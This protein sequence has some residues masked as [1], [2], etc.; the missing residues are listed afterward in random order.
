MSE[1][2]SRAVYLVGSIPLADAEEVFD[3][4]AGAVGELVPAIPDGETGPARSLWVQCQIPFLLMHP[5]LRMMQRDP[6]RPDEWR[7]VRIKS[8]GIYSPKPEGQLLAKA[9]LAPGVAAEDVRFD[10]LGYA[11]WALE[12][13][14]TFSRLQ[15]AGT[16]PAAVRFQVCM[17][18]PGVI[19]GIFFIPELLPVVGRAYEE[20]LIGEVRRIAEAIPP[21]RLTIQWDTTEPVALAGA[22]AER[23]AEIVGMLRR[24]GDAVPEGANLGYHL[25]YGDF[26]HKHAVE[27]EDLGD[28]VAVANELAG[29]IG[30]RI[31]HIH[32]PVPRSRDDDAYFAP[33]AGLTTAPETEL[34][35]GLVHFGDGVEGARR[36]MAAAD[37]ARAEYGIATEC[38]FGRRDPET[39]PE[40]L[41]IHAE[42]ARG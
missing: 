4:V 24:V 31:D 36:R 30:R 2:S 25:C 5:Q 22:S 20:G 41:R 42:A 23:R 26:E 35:L 28:V 10:D 27:P 7:P 34:V 3:V 38:G 32:M 1:T 33:L 12:S 37:R 39:I 17:P 8:H 15:D 29:A 16:I 11:D 13:W 6:E 40:L 9:H 21:E 14:A 18:S 19:H